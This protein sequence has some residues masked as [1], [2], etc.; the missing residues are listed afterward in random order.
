MLEIR[1]TA[2]PLD[3]QELLELEKIITDGDEKSAGKFL[4]KSIYD[5]V[6]HAQ[7]SQ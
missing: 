1:R 2:I 7:Q 5:K 6:A 3:E 4:K